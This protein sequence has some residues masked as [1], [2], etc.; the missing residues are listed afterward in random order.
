MPTLII[1]GSEEGEFS[2]TQ[3]VLFDKMVDDIK[4][5]EVLREALL[6]LNESMKGS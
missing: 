6:K 2:M 4:D 5:Y 1:L 3:V